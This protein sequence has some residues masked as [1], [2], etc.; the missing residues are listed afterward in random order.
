LLLLALQTTPPAASDSR[1]DTLTLVLVVIFIAA[2]LALSFLIHRRESTDPVEPAPERQ[3]PEAAARSPLPEPPPVRWDRPG[4]SPLGS[5]P[6]WLQGVTIPVANASLADVTR[7]IEALLAARRDHDLSAALALYA[8]EPRD[9]LRERL[10]IDKASAS[11]VVF[12]GDPPTLRSAEIVETSGS[13]MKVRAAY[14][15]GASELYALI[16]IEGAW[17]IEEITATR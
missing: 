1:I 2:M 12:E 5:I 10:G 13:R 6:V 14:S 4:P 17:R 3:E 16:W 8:P 15:S 7:V 11:A 9:A